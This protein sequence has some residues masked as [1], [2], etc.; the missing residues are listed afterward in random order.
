M[1]NRVLLR[2]TQSIPQNRFTQ[3]L[4]F[5]SE[6]KRFQDFSFD[7]EEVLL[8]LESSFHISGGFQRFE[9]L[10]SNAV[11]IELIDTQPDE[12]DF[13]VDARWI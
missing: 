6:S 9:W 3:P 7:L 11:P 4:F 12:F 1:T 8:Q 5:E 2:S 10:K 13:D